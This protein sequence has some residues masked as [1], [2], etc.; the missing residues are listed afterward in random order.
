VYGPLTIVGIQDIGPLWP[1]EGKAVAYHWPVY[2]HA[3]RLIIPLVL[4][5]L[6]LR[7]PNRARGAWWV[8]LPP[9]VLPAAALWVAEK[10][11]ES[12]IS[13][14]MGFVG[15]NMTLFFFALAFLWLMSY[16]LGN[17]SRLHTFTQA[18]GLLALAG[19]IGLLGVSF[20]GYDAMLILKAFVYSVFIF[21]F[22]AAMALT[23][24]MSRKRYTPL[25][26]LFH[27]FIIL[28]VGIAAVGTA[29]SVLL[30]TL[31]GGI[32]GGGLGMEYLVTMVVGQMTVSAF[33]GL[34]L[35][36]LLLPFL[37]LALWCPVYR[38]RFHAIFRL[39]GMRPAGDS[40]YNDLTHEV[41]MTGEE[42]SAGEPPET[43]NG[44]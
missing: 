1:R 24:F 26:F 20:F 2:I 40:A 34:V 25:W 19:S 27:F 22:L 12:E 39:P 4:V 14:A 29:L 18:L 21:V 16:R 13:D 42:P 41:P 35:F 32:T 10:M 8:L 33:T 17:L 43:T 36:L 37:A 23:A 5:A 31:V 15:D 9:L 30:M 11:G 6:L 44:L 38:Q 7:R 28:V 3:A